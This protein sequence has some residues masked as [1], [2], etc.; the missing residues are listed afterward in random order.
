MLAGGLG[1]VFFYPRSSGLSLPLSPSPA[2]ESVPE[3][4]EAEG[5]NGSADNPQP[6]QSL[7]PTELGL[8][9]VSSEAG[10]ASSSEEPQLQ[11]AQTPSDEVKEFLLAVRE[12]TDQVQLSSE[13][14]T[15]LNDYFANETLIPEDLL[16]TMVEKV[17]LGAGLVGAL[18]DI[19]EI[20]EIK[21]LLLAY[22]QGS[23]DFLAAYQQQGGQSEPRN[24]KDIYRQAVNQGLEAD[25]LRLTLHQ[26]YGLGRL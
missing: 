11:V 24:L 21:K 3:N 17:N 19:E 23:G 25:N 16:T 26:S 7:T 4:L 8:V 15:A 22:Y 5:L 18:S 1:V 9:D 13:E 6:A 10:D 2:Y 20:A 12:V 14:V